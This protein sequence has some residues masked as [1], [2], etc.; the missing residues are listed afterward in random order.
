MKKSLIA[1][2]VLAASG[3]SFAQVALTGQVTWG[4]ASSTANTGA[5]ASGLGVDT[6]TFNM[7][8]SEDLG[9]GLKITANQGMDTMRRNSP[10]AGDTSVIVDK[11]GSYNLLLAS[12]LTTDYVSTSSVGGT[13]LNGWDGRI[14]SARATADLVQLTIPMGAFNVYASHAEVGAGAADSLGAVGSGATA[15]TAT[16]RQSAL[17]VN[18]AAGALKADLMIANWDAQT[19]GFKSRVRGKASYDLGAAIIGGGFDQGVQYAGGN[20]T[21]SSVSIGVPVGKVVLGANFA[22]RNY[23]GTAADSNFTGYSVG[24]QYNLSKTANIAAQ[25]QNWAQP[26]TT[27]ASNASQSNLFEV[28]ITKSF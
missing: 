11:A 22:A 12:V 5:Q 23:A 1:L 17:G 24:A 15:S 14:T 28:A 8:A 7:A 4:Y 21:D 20:R 3:A 26:N 13:P 9:G 10:V 19:L 16:Q 6:A 27:A 2:A 18:Y 25:Y